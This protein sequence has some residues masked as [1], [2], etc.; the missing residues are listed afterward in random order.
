MLFHKTEKTV[1]ADMRK[2][3]FRGCLIAGAAGDALGYPV[4]FQSLAG[5]RSQYGKNGITEYSLFEGFDRAIV[6]DDTQMTLFTA[7]GLLA[8]AADGSQGSEAEFIRKAYLAWLF[9][10]KH[11]SQPHP[12]K[13]SAAGNASE[14]P[15]EFSGFSLMRVPWLYARRAPG[16]TCLSALESGGRGT[17]IKPVNDSKGCGGI[18]RTAPA[19]LYAASPEDAFRIGTEAAALT[20]GHP[21]GW[22]PAGM[23]SYIVH[24]AAY[25]DLPLDEAAMNALALAEE[26]AVPDEYLQ[27]LR[28]LT[29]HA[30]L[31]AEKP[32]DTDTQAIAELGEGWV[33]EE[34]LAVSLYCALRYPDEPAKCLIAAVNHD[35]DSDSTG[36]IAG[37]ML[38]ARL[39]LS[40]LP[41]QLTETLEGIPEIT[42][43][44]DRLFDYS[45]IVKS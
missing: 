36:A 45:L 13:A 23:L 35:G 44:A 5:I 22:L 20:H 7:E 40:A 9:T 17:V 28:G 19:G 37:N 30:I 14:I 11:P 12:F 6:T 10:Q 31:L 2:D 29:E 3:K 25:T 39:G 33:G 43:M 34:A 24:E 27:T 42:E 15:A 32:Y 21:L 4:E 26:Y 1:S 8:C 41:K 18:M 38:G 16:N